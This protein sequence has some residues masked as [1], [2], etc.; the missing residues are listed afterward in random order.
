MVKSGNLDAATVEGFGK[1]CGKFTKETLSAAEQQQL[2]AKYFPL[3]D[4]SKKPK[5]ALDMR[6]VSGM[7]DVLVSPLVGELDAT[8][9]SSEALDVARRN[10]P[11][12]NVPFVECSPETLPFPS[13]QFDFI[14]LLGVLH[15]PPDARAEIGSLASKL[16]P[17]GR[18][19]S[20][21][22]YAFANRPACFRGIWK[23]SDLIRTR[24]RRLPFSLRYVMSNC[25]SSL[26]RIVASTSSGAMPW[27]DSGPNRKSDSRS[28]KSS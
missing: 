2:F 1:E 9:A 14:F 25:R 11:E 21:F 26:T 5:R 27:I 24:V 6:S 10:V 18:L 7:W 16:A 17:D 12:P 3:S 23:L 4:W 22:C 15:H 19:F 20:Y 28:S 13:E 8:D